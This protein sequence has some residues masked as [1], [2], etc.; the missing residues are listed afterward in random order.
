MALKT[1]FICRKGNG[2]CTF[3]SLSRACKSC[4]SVHEA[5]YLCFVM[6]PVIYEQGRRPRAV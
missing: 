6:D 1:H 2:K 5:L 4:S 3:W